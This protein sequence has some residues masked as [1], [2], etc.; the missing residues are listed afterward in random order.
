[1]WILGVI[2]SMFLNSEAWTSRLYY[3][4]SLTCE[5]NWYLWM[6]WFVNMRRGVSASVFKVLFWTWFVNFQLIMPLGRKHYGVLWTSSVETFKFH[7]DIT[8]ADSGSTVSQTGWCSVDYF[9]RGPQH[10]S[11][12]Y[13]MRACALCSKYRWLLQLSSRVK[14]I[15]DKNVVSFKHLISGFR[16]DWCFL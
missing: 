10:T 11:F 8:S 1:M 5:S 14:K 6:L 7:W 9:L 15:L 4:A 16:I 12:G 13:W 3:D 2:Y